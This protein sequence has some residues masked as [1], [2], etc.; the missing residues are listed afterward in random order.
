M[1]LQSTVNKISERTVIRTL[2]CKN[3]TQSPA[4]KNGWNN[5]QLLNILTV[6]SAGVICLGMTEITLK[7]LSQSNKVVTNGIKINSPSTFRIVDV[8]KLSFY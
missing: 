1:K 6:I 3:N 7:L 2:T 8:T 4:E 5:T